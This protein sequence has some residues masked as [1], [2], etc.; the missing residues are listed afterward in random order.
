VHGISSGTDSS[1]G[2]VQGFYWIT[3][4]SFLFL[5]T[6]R[7]VNSLVGKVEKILSSPAHQ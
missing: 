4:G 3:G 1:L 2:W 6:Y 7:I 5:L